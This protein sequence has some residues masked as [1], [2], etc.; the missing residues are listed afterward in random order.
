MRAN[1]HW[2]LLVVL[3]FTI[4]VWVLIA[5]PRTREPSADDVLLKRPPAGFAVVQGLSGPLSR[6]LRRELGFPEPPP[7]RTAI[8]DSG[9]GYA[10]T[11]VDDKGRAI[12]AIAWK[13]EGESDA[14]MALWIEL[15]DAP[16]I[17]VKRSHVPGVPGAVVFTHV[18]GKPRS[19]ARHQVIMR[20]GAFLFTFVV[21]GR[22]AD[23]QVARRLANAQH[24]LAPTGPSDPVPP[25]APSVDWAQL[26]GSMAGSVV[27]G[28]VALAGWLGL[29]TWLLDRLG[30]LTHGGRS[31]GRSRATNVLQVP[32]TAA[33]TQRWPSSVARTV[34]VN[35]PSK[36]RLRLRASSPSRR[37]GS[38]TSLRLRGILAGRHPGRAILLLAVSL[39]LLIV[40][41]ASVMLSAFTG[42]DSSSSSN[43]FW[44]LTILAWLCFGI[45][46]MTYR[47]A[48]RHAM[49]PASE[50][51][52]RDP[53]P[54]VLYL[55]SFK[56]DHLKIRV[57]GPRRR[58]W[59]DSFAHPRV[60]RFE[61]V[62]AWNLWQFGPVV[63]LGLPGQK[64]PPLG[65]ARATLSDQSWRQ[66]IEQWMRQAQVIVVVLGRS[67]GLAW[68][69]SRLVALD[70]WYKAILVI[71]PAAENEV[72]QRWAVFRRL[73]MENGTPMA[74]IPDL[75]TALVLSPALGARI[76]AFS[77]PR[78][79]ELHYQLAL[80][81]AVQY[82]LEHDLAAEAQF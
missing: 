42:M 32:A 54:L 41:L 67:E 17:Q 72:R 1:R 50:V 29:V 18:P 21:T 45:T 69:I 46:A 12:V 55:R 71:P 26:L 24:R 13:F 81:G 36:G 62:L 27:T 52:R 37:N 38:V 40:G 30:S 47:Q 68:E 77:S 49:P 59:L 57:G 20:Q 76:V 34:E 70:I 9:E 11:W 15:R 25:R 3:S 58:S 7:G 65:A 79:D 73:T 56:D 63:A 75:T 31:L 61:E 14:G 43:S 53:R 23:R 10:R 28:L 51:L 78:H 8:E 4:V 35:P 74:E 39:V 66:E 64:L 33:S 19:A 6:D 2:A 16:R 48:R 80:E 44:M 22:M 82:L 60:D 5:A